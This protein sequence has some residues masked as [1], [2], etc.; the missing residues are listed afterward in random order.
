MFDER[1][2][3]GGIA[4]SGHT[5]GGTFGDLPTCSQDLLA[6]EVEK[7]RQAILSWKGELS[8]IYGPIEALGFKPFTD[9]RPEELVSSPELLFHSIPRQDAIKSLTRGAL[10]S[11]IAQIVKY[12]VE[13]NY[14][15]GDSSISKIYGIS[16]ARGGA[17]WGDAEGGNIAFAV[18]ARDALTDRLFNEGD[19]DGG[20]VR[21]F[22]PGLIPSNP[23]ESMAACLDLT[24]TD[25]IILVGGKG[26]N[27][28]QM[29]DDIEVHWKEFPAQLKAKYA[30]AS[31]FIS[32]HVVYLPEFSD[33]IY[34]FWKQNQ[35]AVERCFGKYAQPF[36]RWARTRANDRVTINGLSSLLSFGGL[37][38][39]IRSRGLQ[40]EAW[41]WNIAER[42]YMLGLIQQEFH[43]RFPVSTAVTPIKIEPTDL[44]F[45]VPGRIIPLI[46]TTH[47]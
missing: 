3:P 24:S 21:I 15:G 43:G 5:P 8:D 17:Y 41:S 29:I 12:G 20:E 36:E 1:R 31:A 6:L 25:L 19:Y 40:R 35:A 44:H 16:L 4:G 7:K 46:R 11:R 45:A 38:E 42:L 28:K 33:S 34:N 14:T 2:E 30:S 9:M 26:E 10:D 22:N 39:F 23:E 18:R 27:P 47:Q 13:S 32:R 37:S